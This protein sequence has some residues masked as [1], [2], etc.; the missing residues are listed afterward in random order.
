MTLLHTV[1]NRNEGLSNYL[2]SEWEDIIIASQLYIP[3]ESKGQQARRRLARREVVIRDICI[4]PKLA[5]VAGCQQ[6]LAGQTIAGGREKVFT[7][8]GSLV[9]R[10]LADI[11]TFWR[12]DLV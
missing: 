4:R 3:P 1:N 11:D 10:C 2:V 8:V 5:P 6:R 9:N 7:A 12:G